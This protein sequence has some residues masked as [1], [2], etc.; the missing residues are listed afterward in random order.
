MFKRIGDSWREL[1]S[2]HPGTRF[3]E[4]YERQHRKQ[5]SRTGRALRIAAGIILVPV[6]LFFLPAPGPGTVVLALGA[7]MIAREFKFAA[8]ALDRLELRT[9]RVVKWL[10]AHRPR[11]AGRHR[12]GNR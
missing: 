6:G 2:G 4:Q 8:K 9:R 7:I 5:E 11:L 3:Q 12:T 1:K 10:S